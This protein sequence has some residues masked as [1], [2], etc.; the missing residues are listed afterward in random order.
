[1][2]RASDAGWSTTYTLWTSSRR[3]V[4]GGAFDVVDYEQ[5]EGCLLGNE[6][7]PDLVLQR[8]LKASNFLAAHVWSDE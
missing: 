5:L 8:L 7:D 1:M 4:F 6:L 2:Q 3:L